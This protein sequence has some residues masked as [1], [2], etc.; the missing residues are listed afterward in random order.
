VRGAKAS[1]KR[2]FVLLIKAG[3]RTWKYPDFPGLQLDPITYD[4]LWFLRL[5]A[6][7]QVKR[8]N[9]SNTLYLDDRT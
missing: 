2:L 7:Q 5:Y 9:S 1:L 8:T 6:K 4:Y 3:V